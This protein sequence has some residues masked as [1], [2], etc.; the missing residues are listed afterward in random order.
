CAPNCSRSRRGWSP[1]AAR[2]RRTPRSRSVRRTTDRARLLQIAVRVDNSRYDA[3]LDR[4]A[5]IHPEVA[6]HVGEHLLVRMTRLLADHASD[7][8]ARAQNLLRLDR[9][10]GRGPA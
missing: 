7:A 1:C 5:G 9:D 6:L 3:V 4:L 10:V 8:L 2:G